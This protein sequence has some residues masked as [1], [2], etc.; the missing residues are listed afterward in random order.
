MSRKQINPVLI[1][2]LGAMTASGLLSQQQAQPRLLVRPEMD[3][4][5][6]KPP[7][8]PP[9]PKP[10]ETQAKTPVPADYVLGPDDQ[11]ALLSPGAEELNAKTLRIEGNGMLSVPLI[12]VVKASGLTANEL[13]SEI[14]T[15]LKRY[16]KNPEV[17]V[18]VSE[19]RSQ[20]VSVIGM[21]GTPGV[22]QLQG[23]KTLIEILSLAGGLRPEAGPLVVVTRRA[24]WGSLPIA[25]ATEDETKQFTTGQIDLKALTSAER[26]MDN[27]AIKPGDIISVPKARMV[28]VV[29][30]VERSGG[31]ILTDRD[32]VSVLQALSLAGGLKG[33]AAPKNA[34][35]LRAKEENSVRKDQPVNLTELLAGKSNDLNM[36]AD[37]VLFIPD[38][39]SKKAAIRAAE[40]IVQTLTGV[41]IWRASAR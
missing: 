19:Y 3:V 40:A 20:S 2:V 32:G 9:A 14:A 29:G 10:A 28:Y 11:V 37:D 6:A 5:T 33:T 41:V 16:Y 1:V 26:P 38:S 7:E 23:K 17:V 35:I 31:F 4:T 15:K 22:H 30:E 8:L 27:I 21:V 34:H 12:G 36:Q 24:E 25:G 18:S 13:G 39:K